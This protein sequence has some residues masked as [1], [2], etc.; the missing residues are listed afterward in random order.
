MSFFNTLTDSFVQ[1]FNEGYARTEKA[2][3]SGLLSTEEILKTAYDDTMHMCDKTFTKENME[4]VGRKALAVTLFTLVTPTELA[5]APVVGT[6][7]GGLGGFIHE[8]SDMPNKINR[9]LY[10]LERDWNKSSK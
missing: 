6:I 1:G 4:D 5:V 10:C 2:C 7:V 8:V 3:K 9:Q